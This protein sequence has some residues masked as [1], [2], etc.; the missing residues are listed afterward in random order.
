MDMEPPR[1][2]STDG[3]GVAQVETDH[4][5]RWPVCSL[6]FDMRDLAQVAEHI[7]RRETEVLKGPEPREGPV[8]GL[9]REPGPS[10]YRQGNVYWVGRRA[11]LSRAEPAKPRR[12]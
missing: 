4:F 1:G 6:W 7:H 5:Q 12:G 2:T 11:T 8:H 9:P 3:D 10:R